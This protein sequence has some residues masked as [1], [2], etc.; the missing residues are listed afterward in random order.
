MTSTKELEIVAKEQVLAEKKQE[1]LLMTLLRDQELELHQLELSAKKQ[2]LSTMESLLSEKERAMSS[3]EMTSSSL[4]ARL[5][6]V[7][8]RVQHLE[9]SWVVLF[10]VPT[11]P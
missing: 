3:L 2:D 11:T 5:D 9:V 7:Q 6:I 1:L 8:D 4:Q 10:P